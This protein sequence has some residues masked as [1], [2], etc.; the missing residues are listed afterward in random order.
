[1]EKELEIG[2]IE[3]EKVKCKFKDDNK[4]RGIL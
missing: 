1:M 4:K 3:M 2:I